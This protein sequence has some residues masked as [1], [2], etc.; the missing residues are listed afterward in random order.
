MALNVGELY[1]T[2]DLDT[3]PF[4]TGYKR[5]KGKMDDFGDSAGTAGGRFSAMNNIIQG[6][7]QGIGQAVMG[8]IGQVIE[9]G[10]QAIVTGIQYNAMMEQSEI[11]WTTIL[12]SAEKAVETMQTLQQL[13]AETPFEFEE[14]DS[15][16]KLLNMAGFEG[17]ELFKTLVNVGDAV[18]A[19]GGNG[20][21]LEGIGTA[22]FQMA[23]K[24]KVSAEE[25]NQLA[26]RG[27]PAWG[28]LADKMGV[29]TGELM[30]M[31]S[32]GQMLA[33]D[34]IPLLVEGLGEKFGGSMEKQSQTFNGLMS[35]MRDNFKM[36]MAEVTKGLTEMIKDYLPIVINLL[37]DITKWFQNGG[38]NDFVDTLQRV[39]DKLW[40]VFGPAIT[41][42]IEHFKGVLEQIVQFFVGL[43]NDGTFSTFCEALINGAQTVSEIFGDIYSVLSEFIRNVLGNALDIA[44]PM[45]EKI[46]DMFKSVGESLKAFWD[47]HGQTITAIVQGILDFIT[48]LITFGLEFLANTV[49]GFCNGIKNMIEGALDFIGGIFDT[50]SA[51]FSGD[52]NGFWEGIK[53][54]LESALQFAWGLVET[55][56]NAK[57]L[58]S[59]KSF[60]TG[61][62]N[63]ITGWVNNVKSWFSNMGTNIS[64]IAS[65][66]LTQVKNFF[67]THLT[68]VKNVVFNV[69]GAVKN[70][71]SGG[72]SAIQGNVS[73][74][75]NAIT[76]LGTKIKNVFTGLINSAL[77]WGKDIVKGIANGI[78]GAIGTAIQAV[79]NLANSVMGTFKK[80]LGIKSPSRK[81]KQ[82]GAWT[83]EGLG[84]GVED[85]LDIAEDMAEAMA[86][87]LTPDFSHIG[88]PDL[89]PNNAFARSANNNNINSSGTNGANDEEN[90][91][92]IQIDKMEVRNDSDIEKVAHELYKLQARQNRGRK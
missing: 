22:I 57:I 52:W 26:E 16:A 14:L 53:E 59:I 21:V 30:D 58:G 40:E 36:M 92:T 50:F 70:F 67:S 18:S 55:I 60:V 3:Q 78:T 39:G 90:R 86:D 65:S 85:N 62:G 25:M 43:V 71:F 47:E 81:F 72:L 49:L 20:E 84:I 42:M 87:A 33:D 13:G 44:G 27:I 61:A 8:A 46:V 45:I 82:F 31:V 34:V 73:S 5:V 91:V 88:F 37:Q 69:I 56:F 38:M 6:V 29:S 64:N 2:C 4:D 75:F 66:S 80:M 51:L 76:N 89:D 15:T 54:I 48:P 24:G 23:T 41:P 68:N 7:F 19:I 83:V 32:S 63:V 77:G 11:A 17:E 12:G 28:I 9:F 1:A 74:I 79:K 35:T 10:K